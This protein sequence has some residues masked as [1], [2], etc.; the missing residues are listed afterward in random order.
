MP[1]SY[2]DVPL[3]LGD[4]DRV[5]QH[6]LDAHLALVDRHFFGE[7]DSWYREGRERSR[8]A[9]ISRANGCTAPNVTLPVPN[10]STLRPPR[11]KLGS[12]WWPTGAARHSVGLFLASDYELATIIGYLN[13]TGSRRANL[14]IDDTSGDNGRVVCEQMYMLPPM[15][16]TSVTKPNEHPLSTPSTPPIRLY[17]DTY[18]PPTT[19]LLCFVDQRYFWPFSTTGNLS[20]SDGDT[21]EDLYD[22][23]ATRLNTTITYDDVPDAYG[24]PDPTE[25]GRLYEDP[26]MMLDAI[27]HSVGQRIVFGYDSSVGAVNYLTSND[28]F[29]ANAEQLAPITAGGMPADWRFSAYPESVR[30][31]FPVRNF[32]QLTIDRCRNVDLAYADLFGTDQAT[33]ASGFK[34]IYSTALADF[35]GTASES[36][37]EYESEDPENL[38][39]LEDLAGIIADDYYGFIS[40]PYDINFP[41]VFKWVPEG[42]NDWIWYHAGSQKRDTRDGNGDYEYYTRAVSHPINFGVTSQLSQLLDPVKVLELAACEATTPSLFIFD[43]RDYAEGDLVSD[44]VGEVARILGKCFEIVQISTATADAIRMPVASIQGTCEGCESSE[45]GG[46]SPFFEGKMIPDK[47]GASIN[48]ED[49]DEWLDEE[50]VE[51]GDLRLVPDGGL[52]DASAYTNRGFLP[53]DLIR[54]LESRETLTIFD[55][56]EAYFWAAERYTLADRWVYVTVDS[57]WGSVSPPATTEFTDVDDGQGEYTDEGV[58]VWLSKVHGDA[59]FGGGTHVRAIYNES[60]G[61]WYTDAVELRQEYICVGNRYFDS[62]GD[63]HPTRGLGFNTDLVH[64]FSWDD[65]TRS[66]VAEMPYTEFD[67]NAYQIR[68]ER[69]DGPD[70]Q[71]TESVDEGWLRRAT[72]AVGGFTVGQVIKSKT[73]RT[74]GATFDATEAGEWEAFQPTPGKFELGDKVWLINTYG[75]PIMVPNGRGVHVKANGN[76]IVGGDHIDV[77]FTEPS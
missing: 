62:D 17:G 38:D 7:R 35:S 37:E 74:T 73:D 12:L 71:A 4:P 47:W 20:I 63:P 70:W 57:S 13:A 39:D 42:F 30:V 22:L 64:G 34:T 16:L 69:S 72:A 51:E 46:S 24:T 19:W 11:W 77:P 55:E 41:G 54:S 59:V 26:A 50:T 18:G 65:A 9:R 68:P 66:F 23:M 29:I 2:A 8:G 53:G 27:A 10:Y 14:V 32:F 58:K 43:T 67:Y 1:I 76:R 33:V 44:R 40:A 49:V 15:R 56:E 28:T 21:W 3:A 48:S 36:S 6:W 75:N 60:A 31:V 25:I 5:F 45:P 61:K 52:Y